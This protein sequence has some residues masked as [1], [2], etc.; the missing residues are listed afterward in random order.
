MTRR[1]H[2]LEAELAAECSDGEAGHAQGFLRLDQRLHRLP[3]I[4]G[5]FGE[6]GGAILML[7][8]TAS[9][10]RGR[11]ATHKLSSGAV[12]DCPKMHVFPGVAVPDSRSRGEFFKVNESLCWIILQG[13][14]LQAEIPLEE[15]LPAS[16]RAGGGSSRSMDPFAGSFRV[17][18]NCLWVSCALTMVICFLLY[19]EILLVGF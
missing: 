10:A 11:P 9:A 1:A 3:A 8:E 5:E 16:R 14:I 13:E 17:P 4:P 2:I 7:D 18:N 12:I 15:S 19:A 6:R